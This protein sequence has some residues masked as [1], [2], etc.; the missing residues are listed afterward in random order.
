MADDPP[1]LSKKLRRKQEKTQWLAGW[2][3]ATLLN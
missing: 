1:P 2:L 3:R